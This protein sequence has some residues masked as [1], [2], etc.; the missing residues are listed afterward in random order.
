MIAANNYIF[1]RKYSV[2]QVAFN[3]DERTIARQ[4]RSC[5][6]S[7]DGTLLYVIEHNSDVI[8]KYSLVSPYSVVG[9]LTS[10]QTLAAQNSD[11]QGMHFNPAGTKFFIGNRGVG[12]EEYTLTTAFDFSTSTFVTTHTN[13]SY[14]TNA[15]GFHF[16]PDGTR[17]FDNVGRMFGLSTPFNLATATLITTNSNCAFGRDITFSADGKKVFGISTFGDLLRQVTLSVAW[18]YT[19]ATTIIDIDALQMFNATSLSFYGIGIASTGAKLIIGSYSHLK[20][21]VFDLNI[22]N[23]IG[24]YIDNT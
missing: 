4:P 6:F 2:P 16:K 5:E 10:L 24:E 13:M 3:G 20:Y 12:V 1:G 15:Y 14:S 18:D 21:R 9:G 19:S 8:R 17:Y 22:H 23:T 11:P 7:A